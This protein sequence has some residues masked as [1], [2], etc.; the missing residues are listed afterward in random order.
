MTE[1]WSIAKGEQ[2][3][4]D[5]DLIHGLG[6]LHE[7]AESKVSSSSKASSSAGDSHYEA[8]L[9]SIKKTASGNNRLTLLVPDIRCANCALS[10]EDKVSRIPG[11]QSCRAS[12]AEH[13]VTLEYQDTPPEQLLDSLSE[14]GYQPY[15]DR[16][17]QVEAVYR[18]QKKSL[19]GRIG[20]AGIGMMQVMMYA[21]AAYLAGD[22]GMDKDYE[23]LMRWAAL[24]IAAPVALYSALPFHKGAWQDVKHGRP[25]M[26]VPVSLAILAAFTL[27]AWATLAQGDHVYF[28][29]VCMFT[30]FLLIGRYLELNSRHGYHLSQNLAENLLPVSTLILEG[31][32]K[33]RVA[34]EKVGIGSRIFVPKGEVIPLD[35]R[36]LEGLSSIDESAFTGEAMPVTRSPGENV[37]AGSTNLEADL[38]IEVGAEKENLVISKISQL[39]QESV[40]YKPKFSILADKVAR[41]FVSGILLLSASSGFYWYL[42]GAENW[43]VISLTVLVVSCP[44]ALSLATPIAYT[45][46][47]SALRNAGVVLSNGSFLERLAEVDSV[48]FDKTGTL[49]SG[50]L[51]ISKIQPFEDADSLEQREYSL[52]HESLGHENSLELEINSLESQI[53]SYLNI[54]AA[55]EAQSPHPIA[56]AF[57]MLTDLQ[58]ES[59]EAIP[60]QGISGKING[61]EYRIGKPAFV[62][63][64]PLSPPNDSL[65]W[66]LLGDDKP[67]CWFGLTDK[68]RPESSAA[69]KRLRKEVTHLA[70]FTGDSSESVAGLAT[71]VHIDHFKKGMSP[72]DKLASLMDLQSQGDRVLMVGDGINDTGA[73][74]VADASIAVSPVDVFVQSAADVTMLNHNLQTI[75]ALIVFSRKVRR[76]IRQN[77]GWALV[78]NLSVIPLAVGGYLLPWMAALGMSISSLVVVF[79]GNRVHRVEI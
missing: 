3:V 1:H 16:N 22:Q 63:G 25:G 56:K 55:L 57:A 26:D 50:D 24:F 35:G 65:Y 21:L 39:F 53:N 52:E 68:L 48:V 31:D 12:A 41:Y 6:P 27:S 74:G 40:L 29:S 62:L 18:E 5:A 23:T 28:D 67:L 4:E 32:T 72:E 69:I 34:L 61:K 47:A 51:K 15:L 78:Y 30:F 73:M 66:I 77:I 59:L 13:R 38:I 45:V 20:V 60:G 43:I 2:L 37:L 9:N 36:V 64:K 49:T 42:S 17:D 44:C 33:K 8:I 71:D 14:L 7:D 54:V 79:N 75:P 19:L 76:V 46:A 70:I 58:A 10:I 11:V